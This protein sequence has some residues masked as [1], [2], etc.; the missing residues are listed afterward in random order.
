ILVWAALARLERSLDGL[1]AGV[2]L[3]SHDRAFLDR[4]VTRVVEIEAE[5]RKV[6]EHAGPWTEY[7]AARERAR[8]QQESAFA[9]YVGERDRYASL[10]SARREQARTLGTQ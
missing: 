6:H 9:A 3:V 2:V 1:A 10:L 5:T 8:E 7:A 4:T